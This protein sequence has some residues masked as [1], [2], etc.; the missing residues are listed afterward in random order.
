MSTPT[1]TIPKVGAELL[2]LRDREV[3]L[4][5]SLDALQTLLS[6]AEEQREPNAYRRYAN[7]QLCVKA[8]LTNVRLL[9]STLRNELAQ[10]HAHQ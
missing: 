7:R 5:T 2:Q 8:E 6:I 1:R 9:M 10:L 3:F 4:D